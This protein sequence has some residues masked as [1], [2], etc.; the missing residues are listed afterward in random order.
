MF[1]ISIILTII[2]FEDFAIASAR[3]KLPLTL[4]SCSLSV[5]SST[6]IEP[7]VSSRVFSLIFLVSRPIATVI[8]LN[9]DPGSKK[10]VIVLFFIFDLSSDFGYEDIAI[11]LPVSTSIKIP[12]ADS[13]L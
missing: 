4:L 5:L 3:L 9:I 13:A 2:T 10:S 7:F 6:L 12:I 11:T 8:G 1:N